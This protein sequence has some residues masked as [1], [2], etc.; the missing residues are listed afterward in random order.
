MAAICF[1]LP[2]VPFLFY[3]FSPALAYS[4]VSLLFTLQLPLPSLFSLFRDLHLTLAER[5][6][7]CGARPRWSSGGRRVVCIR[8]TFILNEIWAKDKIQYI[9]VGILLG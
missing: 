9:L 4:F 1:C 7:S 6:P 3:T 8:G 5:F 2:C